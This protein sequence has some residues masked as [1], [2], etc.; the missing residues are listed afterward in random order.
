MAPPNAAGILRNFIMSFGIARWKLSA[1]IVRAPALW[2]RPPEEGLDFIAEVEVESTRR[3]AIWGR[4][5]TAAATARED[6]RRALI[7]GDGQRW[8]LM[9]AE[10][11]EADLNEIFI[12]SRGIYFLG[13][14]L[15]WS[16][17]SRNLQVTNGRKG[18]A[19]LGRTSD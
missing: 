15:W 2:A 4:R 5:E 17:W 10:D 11:R 13:G 9:A 14:V 3:V 18:L 12:V 1:L 7:A 8:A 6:K 16:T 19:Q